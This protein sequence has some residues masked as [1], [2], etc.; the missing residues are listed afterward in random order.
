[1]QL[2]ARGARKDICDKA[3]PVRDDVAS[4]CEAGK[5]A[6]CVRRDEKREG[7]KVHQDERKIGKR[8]RNR[9][10]SLVAG[11]DVFTGPRVGP[12]SARP[13]DLVCLLD[14]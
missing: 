9:L 10:N 2:F 5:H 6:V 14:S 4:L 8:E 13:G 1:M 3:I 11:E 7:S 12:A